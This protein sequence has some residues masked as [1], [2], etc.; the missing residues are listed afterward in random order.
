MIL[1]TEDEFLLGCGKFRRHEDVGA[2][3]GE[4]LIK[5]WGAGRM[6]S[7]EIS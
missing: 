7:W 1:F 3:G 4:E 2:E 5:G 6:E